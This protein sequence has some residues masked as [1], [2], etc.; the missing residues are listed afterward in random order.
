MKK[1]TV[2]SVLLVMVSLF[3]GCGDSA[4]A[5]TG[6][7]PVV[8]GIALDT[9]NSKGDTLIVSWTPMDSTLV[10][11]YF[12]WSRQGT[13]G[14]WILASSVETS[15][16]IHYANSAAFYTVTA[17]NGDNISAD[18]GIPVNTRTV[19]LEE[20]RTEF[21]GRAVGYKIDVTGDSLITGDP[22]SS[23][24]NQDFVVAITMEL[25]RFV[26]NGSAKPNLWPGGSRTAISSRG[27]SV[28]PAPD[29]PTAWS[30]SILY[31]ENMFLSLASNHYCL[32]CQSQTLPDTLTLTDSL[33]IDGQIQPLRG[34]RV[35]NP[36]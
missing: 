25:E 16:G 34:I 27:G 23:E 4:T 19:G 31:G 32:L 17:F 11:G 21:M 13:E 33:V 28:A 12:L 6:T 35:F 1:L 22:T 36:M 10:E 7:L 20:N 5:I 18:I 26:Y 29:D 9:L 14:A 8:T 2:V 24:F 3:T 15:P 30:D